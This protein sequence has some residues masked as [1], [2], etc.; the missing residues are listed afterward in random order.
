MYL[1]LFYTVSLS[2][3]GVLVLVQWA[4]IVLV[5]ERGVSPTYRLEHLNLYSKPMADGTPALILRKQQS[6][7]CDDGRK[8]ARRE[9]TWVSD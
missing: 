1:I 7:C 2:Y 9:S 5:V 8:T 3:D 6:P 4:R